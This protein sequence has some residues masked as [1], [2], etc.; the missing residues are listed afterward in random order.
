[1]EKININEILKRENIYLQIK[2]FLLNFDKNKKNLLNKRCIYITGSS[3]SGKT[4]FVNEILNELNY[5][6]LNFYSNEIRNKNIIENFNK[7]NL[8]SINVLSYFNSNKKKSIAIVM[9]EIEAMNNGDKAGL[10]ALIKIA[11]PK[12]TKSQ[13]QEEYIEVP[14]I[15]IGNLFMDKKIKE[16]I[17]ISHVFELKNPTNFQIESILIKLYNNSINSNDLKYIINFCQN[18]L[19]KLKLIYNIFNFSNNNIN[20]IEI[21]KYLMPMQYNEDIKDVTKQL[22]YKKYLL[23]E[24]NNFIINETDRTII[25][26]LYHENIINIIDDKIKNIP[27]YQEFLDN[28]CFADYID[29]ITFQKQIWQFNEMSCFIKI[30]FNN[31]LIHTK[32][33]ILKNNE[34]KINIEFTKILT[35]YSTQYNNLIFINNLCMKLNLDKKDLFSLFIR[36]RNCDLNN[37]LEK[38]LEYFEINKL[39]I[40]RIYKYID[41]ILISN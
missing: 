25:G 18:D 34:K 5:D 40:Q 37:K 17:N 19:R 41:K 29:R 32:Y 36:Y 35:K 20:N 22:I 16:L 12:K 4:Y 7:L 1:M 30:Y 6:I 39:D 23:N 26:Y 31:Y 27:F 38:T 10:S 15:I 28:F 24:T 33:N 11:R 13:K 8:S 21:I 14:L 9:D 2:N 3:G